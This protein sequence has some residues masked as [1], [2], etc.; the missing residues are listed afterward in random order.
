MSEYLK[1]IKSKETELRPVSE[2][3]ILDGGLVLSEK[4]I[5]ISSYDM[6]NGSPKKGDMIARDPDNPSDKWL[7]NKEF[8]NNNYKLK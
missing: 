2:T 6:M 5:S 8:F 1:Y 7:V 3:E 4:G